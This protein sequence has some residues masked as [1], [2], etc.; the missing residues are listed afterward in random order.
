MFEPILKPTRKLICGSC[1]LSNIKQK[2]LS[3]NCQNCNA[4]LFKLVNGLPVYFGPVQP[5]RELPPPKL[6][7]KNLDREFPKNEAPSARTL[8]DLRWQA[9]RVCWFAEV[10]PDLDGD[11]YQ[12]RL[13]PFAVHKDETTLDHILTRSS[14]PDLVFVLKN[15]QPAHA[16]CN[17]RRG[18]MTMEAYFARYC[19]G[20][21]W[22]QSIL[23]PAFAIL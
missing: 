17:N 16:I 6:R 14:R 9:T 20:G 8:Y 5:K 4:I 21:E 15:L 18:S 12:C 10:P 13:C 7:R 1:G 23:E 22:A 19:P 11:Y 3:Q 2:G